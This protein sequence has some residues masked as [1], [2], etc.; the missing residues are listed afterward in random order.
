MASLA[1]TKCL[2]PHVC[3]LVL[4]RR[5]SGWYGPT[6]SIT[7]SIG[8]PRKAPTRLAVDH[9]VSSFSLPG[10]APHI[11]LP[12]ELGIC[13]LL[14]LPP[15]AAVMELPASFHSHIAGIPLLESLVT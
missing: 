10:H 2:H 9:A 15:D 12:D 5:L 6:R 8:K 14:T 3:F 4:Y 11:G 1:C 13:V 7:S